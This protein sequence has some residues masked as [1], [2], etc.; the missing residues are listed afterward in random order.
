ML[1]ELAVA[2]VIP[3]DCGLAVWE[4]I[5]SADETA[6]VAD[7]LLGLKLP[8]LRAGIAVEL[9][10]VTAFVLD[11]LLTALVLTLLLLLLILFD[12]PLGAKSGILF[13]V[14]G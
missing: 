6:G 7:P 8:S 12:T 13:T 9:M 3:R 5:T 4:L 1:D 2:P 14:L 11:W 10:E